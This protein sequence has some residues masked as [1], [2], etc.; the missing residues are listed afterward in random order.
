MN[1]EVLKNLSTVELKALVYD[2][3]VQKSEIDN[4]IRLVNQIIQTKIQN[5]SS[6]DV[7]TDA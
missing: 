3:L 7:Q 2:L 1:V 5:V 6:V 4:N